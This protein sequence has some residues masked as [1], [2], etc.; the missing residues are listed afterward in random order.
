M[1]KIDN[2]W[3]DK[4]E[5]L[6]NLNLDLK[7][8]RIPEYA[9][10]DE[11]SIIS[12][13][14]D[15]EDVMSIAS[16]IAKNG[17]HSSAV[18]IVCIEKKRMVVLD[19]NRRLVACKLLQDPDLANKE[20]YKR[21]L[22]SLKNIL[23][24]DQIKNIKITIAPSRDIAEKEIWDI[25]MNPL[26]KSWQTIQKLRK[27]KSL[28]EEKSHT[29]DSVSQEYSVPK[30]KM[31][32]DLIKLAFYEKILPMLS[33]EIDKEKLLRTGFNKIEKIIAPNHGKNFLGYASDEDTGEIEILDTKKFNNNLK[34]I[35]PYILNNTQIDGYILGPQCIASE[36]EQVFT[37]LDS[38]YKKTTQIKDVH[39]K[40]TEEN[41][42][43]AKKTIVPKKGTIKTYPLWCRKKILPQLKKIIDECY[44]LDSNNF[45]N[46]K[47]SLSRVTFEAVLKYVIEETDWNKKKL[48]NLNYFRSAF[49]TKHGQLKTYT[50][51]PELKRLFAELITVTS[52]KK[53]FEAFDL[54]KLHQSIHNFKVG[55]GPADATNTTNNLIPLIEFMLQEELEL[56]KSIDTSKLI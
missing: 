54:E 10:V 31:Q 16:N 53:A 23:N 25:H 19:G 26:M 7:N 22:H 30:S 40:I 4:K 47:V 34:K 14:L 56:F 12:Y 32:K 28:I 11:P 9:R 52:S 3:V 50:D 15:N 5:N 17:Y 6:N 20:S 41:E 36:I 18:S 21:K 13:L 38:H 42:T 2:K 1:K 49:N 55:M 43:L 48:K 37:F 27:Y 51:F 39:K 29:I 35:T 46:A 45:A 24:L 8:P 33:T 44:G